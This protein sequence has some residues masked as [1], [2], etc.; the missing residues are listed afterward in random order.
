M[1]KMHVNPERSILYRAIFFSLEME[2]GKMGGAWTIASH[3]ARIYFYIHAM[4]VVS[5]DGRNLAQKWNW[6][7]VNYAE[8][9]IETFGYI[10]VAE[11]HTHTHT[12]ESRILSQFLLTLNLDFSSL[13]IHRVSC[14]FIR[15]RETKTWIF[16]HENYNSVIR[17]RKR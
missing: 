6:N 2:N 4:K 5:S 13:L 3:S 10:V 16:S 9:S 7:L 8:Y 12:R 11:I 14:D 1:G 15:E 17:G